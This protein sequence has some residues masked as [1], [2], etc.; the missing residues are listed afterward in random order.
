MGV[1]RVRAIKGRVR[2]LRL[3]SVGTIDWSVVGEY[4]CWIG[5]GGRGVLRGF[6]MAL[7]V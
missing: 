3:L 7:G 4:G 6:E 5:M 1:V 2:T